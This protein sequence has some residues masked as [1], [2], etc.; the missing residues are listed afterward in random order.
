MKSQSQV[1][2]SKNVLV[3]CQHYKPEPFNVSETCEELVRQGY[4]VTVLTALPNYPEGF[5]RED[6]RHGAHRDE[7]VCGVRVVRVPIIARGAD[8]KGFNKLKRIANYVSFPLSAWLTRA[9]LD[10]RYDCVICVQFSPILMA[11]P[12]LRIA[13]KQCVPCLLWSFDLWPEDMLTGGLS[14]NGMPYR[15]MRRVS[16]RIYTKADM[17][18]V[19]SPGFSKYF[20]DQLGL[21]DLKTVWLPQ[22]AEQ[23]FENVADVTVNN[24]EKVVFTFAGNV[25]G[26]QSVGTIVRAAA[27]LNDEH[28]HV[29]IVGS[30]SR[31]EACK[32]LAKELGASNVEFTGRMPIEAMPGIYASSDAMLLTLS[33]PVKGGSLVPVYT[34]PR[35]FQSYLAAGKPVLC[36][37]DGT[38][39][40]IV[41]DVGCGIRC[42]A[43]NPDALATAMRRFAELDR[44]ER[45]AMAER[46]KR[47]YAERFSRQ[48]FFSR[49]TG[50]IDELV[51]R[52]VTNEQ[53]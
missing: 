5:V 19:T 6:Y 14:R 47:L 11:L 41:A 31:L 23:I 26:N 1:S 38:V 34:I 18:A 50:I 3:V 32:K 45:A 44:G 30:G 8:L 37:V 43:D 29:R 22:F 28:I 49:L 17:V 9:S 25:G 36:A 24:G 27:L 21:P 46:A 52:K 16:R 42:D 7:M 53:F 2:V 10:E 33:K 15:I 20:D 35:K 39:G 4:K 51:V 48:K 12:A 40:E 13:R